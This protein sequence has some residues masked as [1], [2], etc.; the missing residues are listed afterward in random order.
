MTGVVE[1]ALPSEFAAERMAAKGVDDWRQV[2]ELSHVEARDRAWGD[3]VA[4]AT[5]LRARHPAIQVEEVV[6][7]GEPAAELLAQARE[8]AADLLIAGARGY[9]LLHGLLLGSVSE[10]LV[11]EAPCPTLVVRDAPEALA[12]VLVAVRTRDDAERLADACLTL[13]LPAAT[14]LVALTVLEDI[15][16]ITRGVDP[17]TAQRL[18]DLMR[19]AATDEHA[20]AEAVGQQLVERM[21]AEQPERPVEAQVVRGDIADTIL[22]Q[23]A[24]REAGLI[25]VD[26]RERPGFTSRLGLGSVS[27]KLVRRAPTAVLVVRERSSQ[28]ET[29]AT[30]A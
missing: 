10:A 19:E 30:D 28:T 14:K 29:D 1:G 15:P 9:S 4:A 23:A 24:A 3:L 21:H 27:R 25:V 13:P 6:R 22:R 18:D 17:F 2:L 11:T 8:T 20:A 5:D 26:A 12:T 7:A 16:R